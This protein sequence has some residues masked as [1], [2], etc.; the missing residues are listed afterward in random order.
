MVNL[1]EI[2]RTNP[3]AADGYDAVRQVLDDMKALREGGVVREND[4]I[5][6][7]SERQSLSDIKSGF[8]YPSMPRI[9]VR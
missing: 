9:S 3:G 4:L 8:R 6:P 2:L 5:R 7:A 1:T